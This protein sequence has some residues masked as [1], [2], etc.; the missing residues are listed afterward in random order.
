MPVA[1]P[2]AWAAATSWPNARAQ[3]LVLRVDH[4]VGVGRIVDVVTAVLDASGRG[5][6]LDPG[7]RQLVGTTPP[8]QPLAT[9]IYRRR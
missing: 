3:V 1:C 6:H 2:S 8:S 5:D 4:D 7:A 9:G